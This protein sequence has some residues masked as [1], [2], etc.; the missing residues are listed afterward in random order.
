MMNNKWKSIAMLAVT[1][2]VG[3]GAGAA[4]EK[5]AD[6]VS[7]NERGQALEKQYA[8]Q[9][10]ALKSDIMK[11]LP[12][13]DE[14]KTAAFKAACDAIHMVRT[15]MDAARKNLDNVKDAQGLVSHA[16]NNWIGGA[17]AGIAKEEENV[18]KAKTDAERRTAQEALAKWQES[19][20]KGLEALKERQASLDKVK[21]NEP[22]WLQQHEEAESQLSEANA[23]VLSAL[24]ALDPARILASDELD[25]DLAKFVVLLEATPGGLALFAQQGEAQEELIRKML[26]DPDLMLQMLM[27]DGAKGGNYGQAMQ[28]YTDIL[29]TSER[30]REGFLRRL[31]LAVALE[32]AAP[33]DQ[34]NAIALTDA[35]KTVDPVK[36]YL[37][38]EKAY[39][40]D[41]LDPAFKDLSVY[42]YM[43]VV[44]GPEPDEISAWGRQMLRNYRPD[45]IT[46]SDY[47]WRYVNVVRSDVEYRDEYRSNRIPP[48]WDRPELQFY[49]NILMNGGVCGRRSFFGQ[50]ILRAFGIPCIARP[51]LGHGALAHWTPDGWVV[52]LAGG[53]GIGWTKTR[54]WKDLDFHE[55][56]QARESG[57]K[58]MQVKR[59][60]WI[61]DV[62]GEKRTFGLCEKGAPAFWYGVSL[63]VQ[64]VIV[65]EAKAVALAAV[66]VDIGEANETK[67]KVEIEN[68]SMTDADRK[69][70]VG[71]DGTITIPAVGCSK[72]TE[73]TSKII[74]MRSFGEGFQL[75]YNRTG[76]ANQEFEYTFEVPKA[77]TYELTALVATPSWKQHLF[78]STNGSKEKADIAMP[79]TVGMWETT[80]PVEL[81]LAAG[82]NVLTF[83]REHKDL[84]GV[85]IKEL[86]LTPARQA[87]YL[88]ERD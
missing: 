46:M 72:P 37:A 77:G 51:S 69:I 45:H 71:P 49:Q 8:S 54:Y 41:E 86:T 3:M 62:M 65:E 83:S 17:E 30:T 43:M 55:N 60:Q 57:E 20:Q 85:S 36:R 75:H 50:F 68:A 52:C 79:H 19:K 23:R 15:E 42:E 59:A 87:G 63:Y 84:K 1:L 11:R 58:F 67:E 6:R 78:V 29:E 31:A 38:Y 2:A 53:W 18:K 34:R 25:A 26:A 88:I 12:K 47:R 7:L 74:L 39:L 4:E 32:H 21:A 27:A 5:A 9:L 61:G 16:K 48:D 81:T 82:R 24:K 44:D 80:A 22:Q 73:S 56:V 14:Q 28:I 64:R 40:N 13:M 35:P 66:G 33:R 70:V 76:G 10:E